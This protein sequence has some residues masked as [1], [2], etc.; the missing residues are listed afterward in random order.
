[1]GVRVGRFGVVVFG[2]VAFGIVAFGVVDVFGVVGFGVCLCPWEGGMCFSVRVGVT[3][4][5]LSPAASKTEGP[6][7]HQSR[8]AF[9]IAGEATLNPKPN[10]FS[11]LLMEQAV[12]DGVTEVAH[13]HVL[14]V[15]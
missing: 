15:Q 12:L 7:P 13:V 11:H 9:L 2:V 4:T 5:H 14:R 10:H 3:E 6:F 1:M 8:S